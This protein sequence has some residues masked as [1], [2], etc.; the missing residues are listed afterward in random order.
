MRAAVAVG[1]DVDDEGALRDFDLI[2][3]SRNNTSSVP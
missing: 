1:A 2:G 3:A